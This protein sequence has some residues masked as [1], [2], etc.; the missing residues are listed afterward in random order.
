[1]LTASAHLVSNAPNALMQET[2]RAYYTGWYRDIVTEMPTI[3][4]GRISPP[5]GPGLGTRLRPGLTAG[6]GASTKVTGIK[7]L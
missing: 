2:V 6:S 5:P 4:D 1:V 7:D 3:G